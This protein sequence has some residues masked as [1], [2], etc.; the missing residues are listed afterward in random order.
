V[1]AKINLWPSQYSHE[2]QAALVSVLFSGRAED[3]REPEEILLK[4]WF[5]M[6][7]DKNGHD[8]Q[9]SLLEWMLAVAAIIDA[10]QPV[11]ERVLTWLIG[12]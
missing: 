6:P 3:R 11:T 12:Y 1:P 10:L 7:S 4:G 2:C 9:P 5:K 8:P